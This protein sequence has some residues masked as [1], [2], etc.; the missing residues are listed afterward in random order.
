[1]AFTNRLG[2]TEVIQKDGT[3]ILDAYSSFPDSTQQIGDI[4]LIQNL[5]DIPVMLSFDNGATDNMP[6][7]ANSYLLLDLNIYV[8]EQCT[9]LPVGT[10]FAAR[11]LNAGTPAT[12]G[13]MYITVFYSIKR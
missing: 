10:L 13:A 8:N 5:T 7:A 11:R 6:V 4:I 3:D 2:V 12:T 9:S 1:M